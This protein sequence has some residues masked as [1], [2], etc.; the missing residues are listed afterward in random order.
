MKEP[1]KILKLNHEYEYNEFPSEML[2]H[3]KLGYAVIFD[4][5]YRDIS[6]ISLLTN[7]I[8]ELLNRRLITRYELITSE[9]LIG[10]YIVYDI[11]EIKDN[12]R[13]KYINKYDLCIKAHL[14]V[15]QI[16]RFIE[17]LL[18]ISELSDYNVVI[19]LEK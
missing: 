9:K 14:S 15:P 16:I 13:I 7:L 6:W 1:N 3:H 11:E 19:S 18:N 12:T 17:K 4:S 5:V 2:K 8:I 10:P